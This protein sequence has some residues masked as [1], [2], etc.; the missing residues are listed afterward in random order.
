MS[1][2]ELPEKKENLD[3][4]E[5]LEKYRADIEKLEDKFEEMGKVAVD[6]FQGGDILKIVTSLSSLFAQ[7]KKSIDDIKNVEGDDRVEMYT[8]IVAVIIERCVLASDKLSDEE[9]ESVKTYFGKDG[10]V[11]NIID[12]IGKAYKNML[13]KMDTNDDGKVSKEE[14]QAYCLKTSKCCGNKKAAMKNA[15]NLASC[16]FPILSGGN[17]EID[18]NEDE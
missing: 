14:F 11:T 13:E 2:V 16:C 6:G 7:L 5:K 18:I 8:V 12:A 4:P 1:E 15:K 10:L 3:I 17:D 9:K